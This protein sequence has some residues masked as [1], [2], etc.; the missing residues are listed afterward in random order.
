MDVLLT[1]AYNRSGSQL[2]S[3]TGPRLPTDID[4]SVSRGKVWE[5]FGSAVGLLMEQLTERLVSLWQ[6]CALHE[7]APL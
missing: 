7:R 2:M 4:Y 3:Y 5:S 6:K 1:A